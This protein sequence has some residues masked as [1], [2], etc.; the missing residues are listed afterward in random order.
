[1]LYND[2]H[3]SATEGVRRLEVGPL[4]WTTRD[5]WLDTGDLFGT[6]A[7]ALALALPLLALYL[8]LQGF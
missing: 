8:F 2:R 3:V 5:D 7:R 1:M 4:P 6:E